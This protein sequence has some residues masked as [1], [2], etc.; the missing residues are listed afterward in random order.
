MREEMD[1]E[2]VLEVVGAAGRGTAHPV[3]CAEAGLGVGRI[4]GERE[5][6]GP[7]TDEVAVGRLT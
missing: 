7:M 2:H 1:E 6:R 3:S 5:G 4:A